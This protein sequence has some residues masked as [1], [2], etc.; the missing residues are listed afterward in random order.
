MHY[1]SKWTLEVYQT[2]NENANTI[3]H[4]LQNNVHGANLGGYTGDDS[5]V[6]V[7]SDQLMELYADVDLEEIFKVANSVTYQKE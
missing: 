4:S 7:Q 1:Q 3:L 2:R 5:L 6:W